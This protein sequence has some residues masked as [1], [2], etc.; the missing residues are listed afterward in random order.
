MNIIDT[1][2]TNHPARSDIFFALGAQDREMREIEKV[3]T[4]FGLEYAYAATSGLRSDSSQ[5]YQSQGVCSISAD[6][7]FRSAVPPPNKAIAFVECT[8]PLRTPDARLDH[9]NPGDPGYEAPPERYLE[10]S[11]L[12]QVLALL[13]EKATADQRLMAAADHC[14]TAA[15][16]GLCPGVDPG[17]LLFSRSA[18][19]ALM[20]RRTLSETMGSI[21]SAGAQVRRRYDERI[22]ASVFPDPTRSPKDLPEGSAYAG[23]PVIYRSLMPGGTLK[24]MIK[25]AEPAH[26]E[27]FMIEHQKQGRRTYGNPFR[28]YAG[29]YFD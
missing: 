3:L 18:W 17:E 5:A 1:K 6:G 9:H 29:A 28:G 15:Y 22:G 4:K 25:G 8:I 23:I 26:I 12:G 24:E 21:M 2:T 7:R 16:Q 27:A 14:L 10:G 19:Q 13:G 11:S 20:T